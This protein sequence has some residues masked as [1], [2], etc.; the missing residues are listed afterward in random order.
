M[1]PKTAIIYSASGPKINTNNISQCSIQARRHFPLSL[2][3]KGKTNFFL[4]AKKRR[5]VKRGEEKEKEWKTYI[6]I[7]IYIYTHTQIICTE[8]Y[9]SKYSYL[10]LIF[11][12]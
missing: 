8:L 5:K 12:K 2:R 11:G 4:S 1:L 10:A 9:S 3:K 6:Y 7:Y